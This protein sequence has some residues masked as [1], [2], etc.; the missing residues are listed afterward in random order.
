[1][2]EYQYVNEEENKTRYLIGSGLI[3]ERIESKG[4][5]MLDRREEL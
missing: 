5:I 3:I 4:M 2:E 1:M